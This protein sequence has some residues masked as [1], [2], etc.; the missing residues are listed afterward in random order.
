MLTIL[1]SI[2]LKRVDCLLDV[3]LRS[4]AY[5]GSGLGH[6]IVFAIEVIDRRGFTEDPEGRAKLSS[7]VLQ[8]NVEATEFLGQSDL[9]D[10]RILKGEWLSTVIWESKVRGNRNNGQGYT[11]G[12]MLY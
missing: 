8:I 10:I 5:A 2:K 12:K 7:C 1:S 6:Y 9:K 3:Q 11:R 4:L